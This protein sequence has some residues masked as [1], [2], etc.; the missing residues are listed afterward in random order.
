VRHQAIQLNSVKLGR[1]KTTG[2]PELLV[3]DAARAYDH[4]GP[5][6]TWGSGL[7]AEICSAFR[8]NRRL[9]SW[10]TEAICEFFHG[11]TVIFQGYPIETGLYRI[12][13]LMCIGEGTN[14]DASAFIS[15]Q[16]KTS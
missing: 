14:E 16:G 10:R 4:P 3:E 15:F 13:P 11:G 1:Q 6:S 2:Q 7:W 9:G 12:A 5:G 8:K